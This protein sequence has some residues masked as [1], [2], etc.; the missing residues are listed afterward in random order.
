MKNNLYS[1]GFIAPVFIVIIALLVIGCG[2]YFY[3]NK[4][5]EAPVVVNE[6]E[7]VGLDNQQEVVPIDTTVKSTNTKSFKLG[8]LEF[9]Y[10]EILS[11]GA[12]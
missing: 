3:K 11:F 10:P 8:T 4:K 2:V 5:V 1:K 7:N 12:F 6:S 9:S